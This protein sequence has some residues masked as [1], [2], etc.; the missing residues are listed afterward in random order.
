M[1][2]VK[3]RLQLQ[4]TYKELQLVEKHY[5]TTTT[6][7]TRFRDDESQLRYSSSKNRLVSIT[8][9]RTGKTDHSDL[10]RYENVIQYQQQHEIKTLFY[11]M[12]Y[13]ISHSTLVNGLSQLFFKIY[14]KIKNLEKSAENFLALLTSKDSPLGKIL[15]KYLY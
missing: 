3:Q 12:R 4:M 8:N 10:L 9:K 14:K 5:K 6:T 2:G 7:K 15:K 11:I 13:S 1:V